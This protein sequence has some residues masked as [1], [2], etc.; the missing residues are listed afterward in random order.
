MSENN[1]LPIILAGGKSRR[2]GADKAFAKLGHKSLIDY[3]IDK[4]ETKFSEILVIT[5]N[6]IQSSKNNIFLK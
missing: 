1:I 2:F 4:L 5:N 6:P 3:T